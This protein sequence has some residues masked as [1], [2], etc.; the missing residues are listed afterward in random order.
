MEREVPDRVT[1]RSII[2]QAD[3]QPL[4]VVNVARLIR[5]NNYGRSGVAIHVGL[6]RDGWRS[7]PR[8]FITPR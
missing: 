2:I 7:R 3:D 4:A 8:F 5:V 6:L 1:G